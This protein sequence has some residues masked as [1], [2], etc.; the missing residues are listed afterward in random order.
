MDIN[1]VAALFHIHEKAHAMGSTLSHIRD[2]AYDLLIE[3][4]AQLKDVVEAKRKAKNEK[5]AADEADRL[6]AIEHDPAVEPREEGDPDGDG[7]DDPPA[8]PDQ[9]SQLKRRV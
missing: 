9:P 8:E 6:A 3:E 4:N 2:Y 7:D 1:E 5:A